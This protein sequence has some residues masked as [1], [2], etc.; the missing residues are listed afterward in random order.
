MTTRSAQVTQGI[1]REEAGSCPTGISNMDSLRQGKISGRDGATANP[2]KIRPLQAREGGGDLQADH[3]GGD[4]P[5]FV[6]AKAAETA[7]KS[8]SKSLRASG[9]FEVKGDAGPHSEGED[10]SSTR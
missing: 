4:E 9:W 7:V 5:G 3:G 8:A 6:P 2:G 1:R 10:L